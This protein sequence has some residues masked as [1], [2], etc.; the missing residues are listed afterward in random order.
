VA[1]DLSQDEV[2][3]RL[4]RDWRVRV[5]SAVTLAESEPEPDVAVVRGPARRYRKSHPGPRDIGMLIEVADSS[6]AE[7]RAITGPQYARAKVPMY[8]IVNLVER[9]VEVY[10]Q[11]RGGKSP[12]YAVRR[13]YA[14]NEA[15][16]LVLENRLLGHIPVEDLLP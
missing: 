9:K 4:P 3:S 1:V 15:V 5:Q 7:D 13:D 8:W 12:G 14:S 6:L 10:S 2:S 16:P 11:P